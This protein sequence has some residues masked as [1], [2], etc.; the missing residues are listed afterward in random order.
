MGGGRQRAAHQRPSGRPHSPRRISTSLRALTSRRL[1][2]V[3]SRP[4]IGGGAAPSR[5]GSCLRR[6]DDGGAGAQERRSGRRRAVGARSQPPTPHLTSPL[7]GGRDEFSWGSG[8]G[9]L[10]W[11]SSCRAPT[12]IPAPPNRHS[13]HPH[14]SCPRLPSSVI[15]APPNRHSCAGRNRARQLPQTVLPYPEERKCDQCPPPNPA[16]PTQPST[17]N[18]SEQT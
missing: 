7:K 18:K 13:C 12:V 14:P 4:T 10:R 15:P 2:R 17:P 16:P 5:R 8:F 3:A 9:A 11:V 6:N 1:A